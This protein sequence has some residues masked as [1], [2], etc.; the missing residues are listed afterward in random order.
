MY[1]CTSKNEAS[2]IIV[3]SLII[4]RVPTKWM[5]NYEWITLQVN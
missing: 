1:T 5:S 4:A 3:A 2:Q